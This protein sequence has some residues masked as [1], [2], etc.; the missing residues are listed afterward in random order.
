[1]QFDISKFERTVSQSK[2]GVVKYLSSTKFTGIGV[3]T[4]EKIVDELGTDCLDK[5]AEDHKILD[6]LSLSDKHKK[7]I[8]DGIKE[9]SYSFHFFFL[10]FLFNFS[11]LLHFISPFYSFFIFLPRILMMAPLLYSLSLSLSLSLT[12][13]PNRQ[14]PS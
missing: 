6:N 11:F 14:C 5:I 2:D 10:A 3:K 7:I 9:Y 4:A 8:V 1:M 12:Q 13:T